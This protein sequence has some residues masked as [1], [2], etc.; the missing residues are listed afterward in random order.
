MNLIPIKIIELKFTT[1]FISTYI[2]R[3][4]LQVSQVQVYPVEFEMVLHTLYDNH[5]HEG[6]EFHS[7]LV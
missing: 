3:G 5:L 2:Y 7:G 1:F 4:V 6:R